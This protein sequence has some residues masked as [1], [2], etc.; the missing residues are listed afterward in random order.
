MDF[1]ISYIFLIEPFFLNGQKLMTKT[2][3]SWEQKRAFKVKWKAFD[4]IFKGRSDIKN[5]LRP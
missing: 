1:E 2:Q 5:C 3:I 4:I